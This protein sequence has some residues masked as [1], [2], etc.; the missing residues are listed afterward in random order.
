MLSH[1]HE[2]KFKHSFHDTLKCSCSGGLDIE[3][4]LHCFFHYPFVNFSW[5][6]H[7]SEYYELN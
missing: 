7:S 1:L 5:I 3:T 4:V 6:M 2:H